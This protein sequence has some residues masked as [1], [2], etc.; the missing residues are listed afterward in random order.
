MEESF[1]RGFASVLVLG[2]KP[3][4]AV[5][6]GLLNAPPRLWNPLLYRSTALTAE[7]LQDDS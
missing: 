5:I 1:I 3:K 4:T 7:P 6:L 2:E